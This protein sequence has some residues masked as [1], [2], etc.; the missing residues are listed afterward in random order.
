VWS[1]TMGTAQKVVGDERH[2][3]RD[4]RAGFEY[5][6]QHGRPAR[7]ASLNERG[8]KS[9]NRSPY[10][11]HCN[12]RRPLIGKSWLESGRGRAQL[13][14][15]NLCRFRA[16]SCIPEFACPTGLSEGVAGYFY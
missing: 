14:G 1:I 6:T 7:P 16:K 11:N 8:N 9:P 12:Q 5:R 3:A 10:P 13:R 2:H 15:V 4:A